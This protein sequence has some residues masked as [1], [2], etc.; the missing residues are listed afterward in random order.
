M[1]LTCFILIIIILIGVAI[2]FIQF[3]RFGCLP[4][5]NNIYFSPY[6]EQT[7]LRNKIYFI[8]EIPMPRF[9]AFFSFLIFDK[10]KL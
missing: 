5:L 1:M 10:K 7:K 8:S 6:D 4:T 2:P 3:T 9:C